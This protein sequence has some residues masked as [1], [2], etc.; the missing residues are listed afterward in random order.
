MPFGSFDHPEKVISLVVEA[1]KKNETIDLSPCT[2]KRDFIG[3]KDVCSAYLKMADDL[4][5]GGFDI[6]NVCSGEAME[7][8]K[9]LELIAD[10]IGVSHELLNFGKI[11][12]RDG[13]PSLVL[14]QCHKAFSHL[15]WQARSLSQ[16]IKED[17]SL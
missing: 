6:F 1:L 14:G 9:F 2:Q 11:P 17:I 8:S 5:R 13:E 15:A 7:L 16:S 3:I 10:K 12:M 4:K